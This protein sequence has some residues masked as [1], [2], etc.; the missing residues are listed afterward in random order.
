VRSSIIFSYW[1]SNLLQCS[2]IDMR[3]VYLH[4]NQ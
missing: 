4:W 3:F 1:V 2:D